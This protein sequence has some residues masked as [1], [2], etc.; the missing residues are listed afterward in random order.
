MYYKRTL[1]IWLLLTVL[2]TT[3]CDEGRIEAP[4]TKGGD[5]TPVLHIGL[6]PERNLFK[7]L[8][9]YQPLAEYLG[10]KTGVTIKLKPLTRYGN[11]IENFVSAGLDAAF[12][13]SFTYTL[14][15]ARLGVKVIARPLSD[16]GSS[17]YHGLIMVR[18][19]SG[20]RTIEDMRGKS[21]AFVD[22]ATTAGYLLPLAYFKR[23]GVDDYKSFLRETYFAGTH[24][25]VILDVLNK[26]VDIGAAKN[27]VFDE[28]A[29]KDKRLL[30]E[31]L[32]L[33]RSAD[34]PENGLALSEALPENIRAAIKAT[35][36]NMHNDPDGLRILK[37]FGARRFI[38][39]QEIDY[40]NVFQLARDAGLDLRT[41]DYL[42]D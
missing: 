36:L 18:R 29:Q 31:L 6:I 1:S 8:D 34:V 15:H 40:A 25:D 33:E 5:A 11:I 19:D 35:L 39:T 42:N 20:I 16:T 37:Q 13:G 3:G 7:Q 14:A 10:R 30:D 21:F 22:K 17:T 9:H 32:I 23:N 4:R 27:T 41:Y 26:R 12:F 38:E 24:E 2:L 28:L